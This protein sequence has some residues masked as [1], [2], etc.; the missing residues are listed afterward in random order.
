[1]WEVMDQAMRK[2]SYSEKHREQKR[3]RRENP[4]SAEQ[5]ESCPAGCTKPAYFEVS[6]TLITYSNTGRQIT[7]YVLPSRIT[8]L[9]TNP[10][11]GESVPY[12]LELWWPSE[13]LH[14]V[15]SAKRVSITG[16][17]PVSS[18]KAST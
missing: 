2:S 3:R 10:Y 17:D 15:S 18:G 7:T 12:V 16:E 4:S 6:A 14:L 9:H 11:G 13:K 1:M 5:D 8:R